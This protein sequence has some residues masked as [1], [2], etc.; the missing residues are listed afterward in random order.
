MSKQKFKGFIAIIICFMV[1]SN[2]SISKA[3]AQERISGSD[4]YSTAV[5]ISQQ[6]WTTSDTVVLAKGTDFPDALAG[7]PLAFQEDA[8]ILLTKKDSLPSVTEKEIKNLNAKTAILLG[9]TAA[10]SSKVE[11]KLEKMG[12]GIKRYGGSDRYATAALIAKQINSEVAVVANGENFPDALAVAPYA[13]KNGIPILLTKKDKLPSAT[14]KEMDKKTQTII[15]GGTAVVSATLERKLP[16][17]KRY[18]GNG[19]YSTTREIVTKL[20][21][22]NESAYIASGEN[23]PDALTG[24]VLAAKKNSP[25][26]LVKKDEI[27]TAVKG[28]LG[29]YKS[30]F[31]IGGEAAVSKSAAQSLKPKS[32]SVENNYLTYGNTD[33]ETGITTLYV[34]SKST[35]KATKLGEMEGYLLY[36][37][38]NKEKVYYINSDNNGSAVYSINVDGKSKKKIISSVD[39][40]KVANNSIYV[41]QYKGDTKVINKYSLDGKFLEQVYSVNG[42]YM[43]DMIVKGNSLYTIQEIN[44]ERGIVKIDL[45]TKKSEKVYS[46]KGMF[47]LEDVNDQAEALYFFTNQTSYGNVFSALTDDSIFPKDIYGYAAKYLDNDWVIGYGGDDL[48][49]PD[50]INFYK[51]K[52]DG[53]HSEK[54]AEIKAG[55]GAFHVLEMTKDH[56]IY[57]SGESNKVIEYKF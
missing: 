2:L 33:F 6:G 13:S 18:A 57:Y 17:A 31:V 11:K 50:T 1:L 3:S 9:G 4:R 30:H 54:L 55:E 40:F 21:L 51:M 24:S 42:T 7:G 36:P 10:I 56:V 35:N 52:N 29:N 34:Y 19:R 32:P 45:G 47:F 28:L 44:N 26:V 25:I 46:G 14:K 27:P 8:P 41:M 15:V 20:P 23:F 22:G 49:A 53:S 37:T 5:Q 39:E 12:L 43:Y 48:F 16:G 38:V